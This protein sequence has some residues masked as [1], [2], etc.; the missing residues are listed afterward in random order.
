MIKIFKWSFVVLILLFWIN[1]ACAAEQ[2]GKAP[3]Q[4]AA[5][6]TARGAPAISIPETS[7]DFGEI[8]EGTPVSHDFLVKNTGNATLE[9]QKVQPG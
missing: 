9:I 1:F 2:A 3:E 6:E 7:H 5:P 8:G 4:T